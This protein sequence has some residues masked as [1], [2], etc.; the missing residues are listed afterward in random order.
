MPFT[1]PNAAVAA[2]PAQAEPDSVDIDI[3]ANGIAGTG[4]VSGCAVTAQ[5]APDMTLAV[6][7]GSVAVDGA[8]AAVTAGN[9][10]IGAADAT[11]PRFDLVVVNGAGAKSVLAGAAAA[12]PAFP[13]VGTANVVLAAVYVPAAATSIAA[14]SLIDKR[15]M[16]RLGGGGS[17]ALRV[18]R[19]VRTAGDLPFGTAWAA[20][21]TAHDLV[22]PAV[23]GDFL[24]VG[25]SG[26]HQFNTMGRF[27][28]L[29]TMVSG[30]PVNYVGGAASPPASTYEGVGAWYCSPNSGMRNNIGGSALP[31]PV[32][33]GDIAGGNVTLRLHG[34]ASSGAPLLF[35]SA[36]RPLVLSVINLGAGA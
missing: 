8:Q 18:A 19:S 3:L 21:T 35:A 30:A 6:A 26:F 24:L 27:L 20:M 7:S 9:V 10:A 34:R 29:A 1:I 11:N 25:V 28:D 16:I 22:V 14:G 15:T 23:A 2:F 13:S 5:A 31:Y 4:V 17:G 33:A 32:V 36:D 12:N